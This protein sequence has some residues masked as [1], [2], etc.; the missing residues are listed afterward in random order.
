MD[1][2]SR[3]AIITGIPPIGLAQLGEK[4]IASA[5]LPRLFSML[6]KD[7]FHFSGPTIGPAT[8]ASYLRQNGIESVIIDYY[9]DE[10][11]VRDCDIIGISSTFM[12]VEEIKKI[13]RDAKSQNASAPV[14]LGGPSSWLVPPAKILEEI[15]EIDYIIPK[16]GEETFLELIKAIRN[17]QAPSN[18]EGIICLDQENDTVKATAPRKHIDF[19][20]LPYPAWELMGI[21]SPQRIPV[22]FIETSRGCPYKCAYCSEVTFWGKPVR[23][24]SCQ[25][26]TDEIR[27]NAEKFGITTFRFTD[28]CFSFPP[29]RCGDICDSILERCTSD[30]I[31]VKW[32]AYAR[33]EDLSQELMHKM[34]QSGCVALDIGLES[35]SAEVLR[36]M[37]KNYD[38]EVAVRVAKIAKETGIIINY[39][40][41]IGFPGET[42]ETIKQSMDLI[43]RAAPDTYS[44]FLFLLRP[45]STIY[46]N[47]QDFGIEG[48][49]F[50][51]RHTT[52]TSDEAKT[53]QLKFTREIT[54]SIPF[55]GGEHFACYFSAL[56]YSTD[57]I[58]KCLKAMRRIKRNPL[59]IPALLT[60]RGAVKKIASFS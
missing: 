16:E 5:I 27:Y 4:G 21:P 37:N 55:P 30:S 58:K 28:S 51:W 9:R 7:K 57:R 33:I 23:Y 44:C 56:G 11:K 59:D 24:R 13:A 38:P 20:N 45:N 8:I 34:K 19:E 22:L 3:V 49:G 46:D 12:E 26:V 53:A 35:G 6:G 15:P 25:R 10:M 41:M 42:Q 17:E 1:K 48:E 60:L 47:Q 31:P 18:I 43:E 50:S 36:R 39:N 14:V 2:Q 40:I 54:S 29:K 32:S 52:M